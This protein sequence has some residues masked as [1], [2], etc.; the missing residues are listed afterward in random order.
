[1]GLFCDTAMIAR[2][3]FCDN[4]THKKTGMRASTDTADIWNR[5]KLSDALFT[6]LPTIHGRP[7]SAVRYPYFFG[8]DSSWAMSVAVARESVR[9]LQLTT[10]MCRHGII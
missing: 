6:L 5:H 10:D 9:E 7:I 3:P 2:M 1:M 4:H 8:A